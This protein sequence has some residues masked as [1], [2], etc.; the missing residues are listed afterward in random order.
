MPEDK[1]SESSFKITDR[2]LFNEEGELRKDALREAPKPEPPK[3]A[4]QARHSNRPTKDRPKES[5]SAED[6]SEEPTIDFA[7]FVLSL[8]TSA[9]MHMGEIPD[10]VTGRP[11]ESLPAARQTIDVLN[12][13]REKTKGNLNADEQRLMDSL[14]YELRLKFLNKTKVVKL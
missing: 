6:A 14:L 3:T 11:V 1:N 8:A 12:I 5:A 13:L 9:M 7:S 4:E 2:R 10:P